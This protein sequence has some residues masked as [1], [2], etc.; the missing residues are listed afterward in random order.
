[1]DLADVD[2]PQ[3]EAKRPKLMVNMEE[4]GWE[5]DDEKIK[6][7]WSCNQI[8]GMIN[9]FLAT[10]EM[11]QTAMLNSWGVNSNSFRRFMSFTK[12]YQGSDNYTY[13]SA[14]R[15]FLNRQKTAAAVPKPKKVAAEKAG[16][17]DSLLRDVETVPNTYQVVTVPPH[18]YKKRLSPPL[19]DTCDEVRKKML[20]LQSITG[21]T[22]AAI[23]RALDV[24]SNSWTP[25]VSQKGKTAG[26]GSCCYYKAYVFLERLRVAR[27]EAKTKA[28]LAAEA[29][30]PDGYSLV[31]E[32]KVKGCFFV[33]R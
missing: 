4:D 24:N 6:A 5:E 16:A 1:M 32:G 26:A 3:T 13:W 25:F 15:F 28:R 23:L 27:G 30:H 10:K 12:P 7:K 21:C 29:L 9:K 2:E 22:T 19:F 20:E 17:W 8:R 33:P 11:T 31:D 18:H 14:T